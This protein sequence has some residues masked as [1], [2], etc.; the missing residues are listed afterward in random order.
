VR[1]IKKH[2]GN[3][4]IVKKGKALWEYDPKKSVNL[5]HKSYCH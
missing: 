3:R 4:D 2:P 5:V 1:V